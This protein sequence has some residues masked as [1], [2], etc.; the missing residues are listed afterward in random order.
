MEFASIFDAEQKGQNKP[1]MNPTFI[2]DHV[3][4]LLK[5]SRKEIVFKFGS[6]TGLPALISTTLSKCKKVS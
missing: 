3:L 6:S 5:G 1:P 2:V 4:N